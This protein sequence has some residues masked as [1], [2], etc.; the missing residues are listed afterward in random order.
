MRNLIIGGLTAVSLG[1]LGTSASAAILMDGSSA[2]INITTSTANSVRNSGS[3]VRPGAEFAFGIVD[4]DLNEGPD[5]VAV[6][7]NADADGLFT[8]TALDA[9][10]AGLFE[11]SGTTTLEFSLPLV[12]GTSID[13]FE[14]LTDLL[15]DLTVDFADNMLTLTFTEMG[16]APGVA[17]AGRFSFADVNAAAVPLPGAALFMLSGLGAMGLRRLRG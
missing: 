3:T 10:G 5:S 7:V 1:L 13:G 11:T 9:A 14:V 12:D 6:D 4:D 17:L 8:I 16:L 2:N 15:S